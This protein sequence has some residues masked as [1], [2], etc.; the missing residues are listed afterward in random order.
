LNWFENKPFFSKR[1]IVTRTREQAS[2][3]SERLNGEGAEVIEI[4]T[5]KIVS[6]KA[7]TQLK[8]AFL[9]DKSECCQGSYDWVFFTSQN[10]VSEFAAF[11]E[12]TGKDSRIFGKAK[13]CAIG[14]ET[15]KSLRGIGIRPDYVPAEFVAEAIVK[16]FKN[17]KVKGIQAPRALILRAK[18]ARDIL[19]EG[20]KKAGFNVSII[21]LYDTAVPKEGASALK[22][23]LKEQVDYITF[24]S[25]STVENFI[26]L[27]GKDYRQKLSGIKFASIGPVTSKSLKKYG[28]KADIEAK[29]YTIDGLVAAIVGRVP[30]TRR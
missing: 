18:K 22:E 14:S 23:A 16:H 11:L 25:S 10:G 17:I 26:T 12:R 7:D 19:P 28:L 2:Q 8:K 29:V 24:T 9:S 20:L 30:R 6:L 27:L 4:P 3:L 15:A 1:I 13:I 21:D 5:I